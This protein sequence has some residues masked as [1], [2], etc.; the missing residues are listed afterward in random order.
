MLWLI[1]GLTGRK[2]ANLIHCISAAVQIRYILQNVF[3]QQG[4]FCL[5][6]WPLAPCFS[7]IF[8]FSLTVNSKL[9]EPGDVFQECLMLP[10]LRNSWFW[11]LHPTSHELHQRASISHFKCNFIIYLWKNLDLSCSW[12]FDIRD[13]AVYPALSWAWLTYNI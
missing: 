6:P 12:L 13:L 9:S 8:H 7:R 1:S 11:R 2:K 10:N 4:D 5:A 3:S